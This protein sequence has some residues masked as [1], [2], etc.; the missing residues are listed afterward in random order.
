MST[1][2]NQRHIL[3]KNN[4][5]TLTWDLLEDNIAHEF[6][7]SVCVETWSVHRYS[8]LKKMT[9]VINIYL[10]LKAYLYPH[11]N[12]LHHEPVLSTSVQVS[13]LICGTTQSLGYFKHDNSSNK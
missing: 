6:L 12:L 8:V 5:F 1:G 2:I 4:E 13:L 11:A 3:C 7:K 10:A 9:I